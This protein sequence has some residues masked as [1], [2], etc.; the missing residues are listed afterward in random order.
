M[1]AMDLQFGDTKFWRESEDTLAASLSANEEKW[2]IQFIKRK[3]CQR[4]ISS[5][6]EI[7]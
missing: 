1:L 6:F 4:C 3:Q 7:M 2:K 5:V